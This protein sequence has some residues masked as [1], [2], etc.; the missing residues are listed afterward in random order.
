MPKEMFNL[1][2]PKKIFVK[3]TIIVLELDQRVKLKPNDKLVYKVHDAFE[4]V[5][6]QSIQSEGKTVQYTT[7]GL[8]GL[9]LNHQIPNDTRFF[10]YPD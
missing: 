3:N 5:S 7:V 2:I 6:I 1:G 10:S 9:K 4:T 8:F